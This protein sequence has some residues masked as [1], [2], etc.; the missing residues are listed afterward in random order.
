[1]AI[2]ATGEPEF[3]RRMGSMTG[4]EAK[5]SG[6]RYV[7]AP[8]LDVNNNADNPVI[9]VR[10]FGEDPEDVARY[11]VAFIEGLQ[12]EGRDRDRKTFSWPR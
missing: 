4:R 3:A 1:M 5:A 2:A 8:V 10:S 11:G 9:N 12:S 7:L 6:F